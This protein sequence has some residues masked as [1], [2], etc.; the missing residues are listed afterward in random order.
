[1]NAVAVILKPIDHGWAV[2]LTDGRE[3]A[4]F[5]G[6]AAKWRATR[7]LAGRGFGY[8]RQGMPEAQPSAFGA[9]GRDRYRT[10]ELAFARTGMPDQTPNASCHHSKGDPH[11]NHHR[12]AN[13]DCTA[14]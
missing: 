5:T 13:G 2:A 11:G 12:S 4:R 14:G 10:G 9:A 7:Y 6:L 3:L 8:D 1:M